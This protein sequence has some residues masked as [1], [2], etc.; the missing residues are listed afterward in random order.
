MQ[1]GASQVKFHEFGS[2]GIWDTIYHTLFI[3]M[4]QNGVSAIKWV[5]LLHE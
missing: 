2:M 4:L 3:F 1:N 5:V